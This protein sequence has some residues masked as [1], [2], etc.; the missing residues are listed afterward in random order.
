MMPPADEPEST[1]THGGEAP[2]QV[3][4]DRGTLTGCLGI[5]CVLALPALLF[6]PVESWHLP[7]W[8]LPLVPLFAIGMAALGAWLLTRVPSS[9]AARSTDPLQPLTKQGFS[10]ILERPA[11]HDNRAGLVFAYVLIF[12][13]IV[14]YAMVTFGVTDTA[15]LAG[16]LLASGAGVTLLLYSVLATRRRLPIPAWW[17]VRTPIQDGLVLQVLP[18]AVIGLVALVWALFVAAG[19]G[20]IWAPIGIGTLILASALIGPVTQ[21]LPRRHSDHRHTFPHHR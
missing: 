6:L 17:W 5:L 2:L 7:A 1:P 9:L 16:T 11:Q 3:R 14:G 8:L 13:G 12:L 19:Q 21:R 15:I 20:Y 18:L 10:P 4:P